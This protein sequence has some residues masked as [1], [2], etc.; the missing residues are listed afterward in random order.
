M[1]QLHPGV[2][3]EQAVAS[4]GWPLR[5]ASALGRTP[6]PTAQELSALRALQAA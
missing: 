5:L 1:A 3:E 2:T 6:P 4:T